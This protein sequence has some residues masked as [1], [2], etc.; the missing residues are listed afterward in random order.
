ME[1]PRKLVNLS[2]T[3]CPASWNGPARRN[4]WY[5]LSS[6]SL[7][8]L[9]IAHLQSEWYSVG[10]ALC[11]QAVASYM[12]DVRNCGRRS[13]WHGVDKYAALVSTGCGLRFLVLSTMACTIQAT[14][15]SQAP[16]F[17]I[18]AVLH[19][20]VCAVCYTRSITAQQRQ[21]MQSYFFFHACWHYSITCTSFLLLL[22]CH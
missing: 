21:D 4:L 1:V 18:A 16:G 13:L 7:V 8:I 15:W 10:C 5:R 3:S 6:C 12:A 14:G 9:G 2:H 17:V 20:V 19:S 11:F 22:D